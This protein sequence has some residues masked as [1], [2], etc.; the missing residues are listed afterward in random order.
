MLKQAGIIA[1]DSFH[2]RY[3]ACKALALQPAAPGPRAAMLSNGAGPMVNALD[4][5]PS[6]GLELVKLRRS[7]VKSMRDHFSFFYLVENPVDVTGSAS[8]EDYEFV[9]RTLL[10]DD[11]VDI[12]M[13]FFV[14]QDTPLDEGI[15]ERLEA[16]LRGAGKAGGRLRRRRLLHE[17]DVRRAG[18]DRGA[19]TARCRPVGGGSGRA[20]TL[21]RDKEEALDSGQKRGMAPVTARLTGRASSHQT[22]APPEQA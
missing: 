4:L 17:E 6:K 1:V 11:R 19:S 13:P 9:I 10:A 3:A 2:E 12:I 18:G 16:L 21:G 22:T 5:F 15:V 8:A 20:R 7:S 14:F